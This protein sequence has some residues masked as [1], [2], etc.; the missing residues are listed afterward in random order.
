M[1]NNM[2]IDYI[3][4]IKVENDTLKMEIESNKMD[5]QNL[6]DNLHFVR[7]CKDYLVYEFRAKENVM[8]VWNRYKEVAIM[9]DEKHKPQKKLFDYINNNY[10]MT[11]KTIH[12]YKLVLEESECEIEIC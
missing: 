7:F 12:N 8:D 5:I 9:R 2:L 3:R 11:N 4:L 10:G 1:N 6:K